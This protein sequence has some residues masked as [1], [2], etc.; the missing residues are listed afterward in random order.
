MGGGG[1]GSSI[2]EEISILSSFVGIEKQGTKHLFVL[3]QTEQV[4]WGSRANNSGNFS[5]AE[6]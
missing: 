4:H 6:F 1:G 3:I 2:V 5:I